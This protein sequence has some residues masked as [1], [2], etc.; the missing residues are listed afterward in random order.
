[1]NM[2]TGGPDDRDAD[3]SFESRLQA[4]RV[5]QGLHTPP[6]PTDDTSEGNGA[7]A[8]R[9]GL[10]L[11]VELVSA[12]VVALAIGYGLDRAFGTKPFL[13]IASLPLGIAAGIL[14][15]WRLIGREV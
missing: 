14:N 11:S 7:S 3:G 13:L 5:K 8:W 2:D 9:I 10:R 6:K 15:V 12:L 4:A 1:M